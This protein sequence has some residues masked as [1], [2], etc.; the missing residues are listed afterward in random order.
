MQVLY[1]GVHT[2]FVMYVLENMGYDSAAANQ[3][4]LYPC[5]IRLISSETVKE[6]Q[7]FLDSKHSTLQSVLTEDGLDALIFLLQ[8]FINLIE[9]PSN[10]KQTL[11]ELFEHAQAIL[12]KEL[13]DGCVIRM[14]IE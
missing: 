4:G 1:A 11:D 6:I 7:T 5:L 12:A 3:L 8:E 9:W 13:K 10:S 14:G 2:E